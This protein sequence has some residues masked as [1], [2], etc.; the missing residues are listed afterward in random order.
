MKKGLPSGCVREG[1]TEPTWVPL[2][3]TAHASAPKL[4]A[5]GKG[6][7]PGDDLGFLRSTSGWGK[8][9]QGAGEQ[10]LTGRRAGVWARGTGILTG[11]RKAPRQL[12]ESPGCVLGRNPREKWLI[13]TRI[14][15]GKKGYCG[16]WEERRGPSARGQICSRGRGRDP[17]GRGFPE[18]MAC[19]EGLE[20][21]ESGKDVKGSAY[22]L[23]SAPSPPPESWGPGPPLR[24]GLQCRRVQ[25]GG[26]R[27]ASQGRQVKSCDGGHTASC[28]RTRRG[29]APPPEVG[30]DGFHCDS[31][32]SSRPEPAWPRPF[33]FIFLADQ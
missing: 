7:G 21:G 33:A 19:E 4:V 22:P 10:G 6:E 2:T 9:F 13:G 17:R 11:D 28:A 18:R 20:S 26:G 24:R 16:G 12:L 25:V 27:A 32:C 15:S 14:R 29:R 1:E 23:L 30:G 8:A 5:G 31:A 3:R